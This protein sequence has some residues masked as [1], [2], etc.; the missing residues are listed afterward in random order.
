MKKNT[1]Q[2]EASISLDH[3]RG[4]VPVRNSDNA[5]EPHFIE[6]SSAPQQQHCIVNSNP[7]CVLR[8]PG[9]IRS[10]VVSVAQIVQAFFSLN[11]VPQ[12]TNVHYECAA[13]NE[14]NA[15]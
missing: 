5:Q 6:R 15:K 12:R 14:L 7:R 1:E 11:F 8:L 4:P 10:S 2:T 13:A 3:K 9:R